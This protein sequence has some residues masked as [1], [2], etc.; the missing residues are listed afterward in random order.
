MHMHQQKRVVYTA[1]P[2]LWFR[3]FTIPFV[4]MVLHMQPLSPGQ[5]RLILLVYGSVNV[6][7]IYVFLHRSFRWPD[8]S[9]ARFMW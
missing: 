6:A 3:Y 4:M 2:C 9:I 7:S 1:K 8:Q 5:H